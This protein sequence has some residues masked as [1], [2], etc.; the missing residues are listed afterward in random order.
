MQSVYFTSATQILLCF[1]EKNQKPSMKED[2]IRR[3][4]ESRMDIERLLSCF[5]FK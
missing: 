2:N 3:N 1:Y 5:C 4:H